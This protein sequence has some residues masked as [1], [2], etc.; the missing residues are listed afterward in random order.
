MALPEYGFLEEHISHL[1]FCD[2]LMSL[3][4][5]H[6]VRDSPRAATFTFYLAA[7]QFLEEHISHLQ[8]CDLLN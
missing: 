7:G 8:F 1:Q 5:K 6:T 3:R 4:S 2:L